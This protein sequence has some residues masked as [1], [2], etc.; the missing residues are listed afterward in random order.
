MN[1]T[2]DPRVRAAQT[3]RARTQA[4][5]L[6]AALRTFQTQG[7]TGS[8]MEEIAASAGVSVATAYKH[9]SGKD[10]LLA[11]VYAPFVLREQDRSRGRV[12]M[13]APTPAA[14][15]AH[16]RDLATMIREQGSLTLAY[17]RAVAE[18]TER[19]GGPARPDDDADPRNIAPVSQEVARLIQRGQLD[20]QFRP[21]PAAAEIASLVVSQMLARAAVHPGEDPNITAEIGLTTLFALL[22]PQLLVEAGL[23]GRPFA[24]N[25]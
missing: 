23:T 7:W 9:F 6:T 19:V 2:T 1:S 24:A 25:P 17:T 13:G 18:Y 3:K 21:H 12:E 11:R 8:R 15:E 22:T 16:V 5:L 20:R 4:A 14:L 10:V